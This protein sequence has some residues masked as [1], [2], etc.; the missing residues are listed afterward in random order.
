MELGFTAFPANTVPSSE[1]IVL[2]CIVATR[3]HVFM[4]SPN[5]HP[6]SPQSNAIA[7]LLAL[8]SYW[9][10]LH[11]DLEGRSSVRGASISGL[12]SGAVTGIGL[13]GYF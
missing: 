5:V 13:S 3:G 12:N 9:L 1:L 11:G 2:P 8:R 10:T 7:D 6:L 4:Y